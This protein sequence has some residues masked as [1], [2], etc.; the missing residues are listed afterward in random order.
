MTTKEKR[1]SAYTDAI[2][3]LEALVII[4]Q[5]AKENDKD[6]KTNI[7]FLLDIQ[8]KIGDLIHNLQKLD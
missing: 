5:G 8:T 7:K 3:Y 4:L 1:N 2:M 6:N